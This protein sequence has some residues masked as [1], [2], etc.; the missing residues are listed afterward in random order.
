MDDTEL[1]ATVKSRLSDGVYGSSPVLSRGRKRATAFY[2][3]L[4]PA[5]L[6]AGNSSFISRDVFDAVEGRK[7]SLLEAFSGNAKPVRFAPTNQQDTAMAEIASVYTD[8]V[9]MRQNNGYQIFHDTIHDSL[10][11]ARN[12]IVQIDWRESHKVTPYQLRNQN[13]DVAMQLLLAFQDTLETYS[14]ETNEDGTVNVELEVRE[15]TSKVHIDV[16]PP[17]EFGVANHTVSLHTT[18]MCWRRKTRTLAWLKRAGY[19]TAAIDNLATDDSLPV[20]DTEAIERFMDVDGGWIEPLSDQYHKSVWVY[21]CY[22]TISD[23]TSGKETLWHVVLAQDTIL[24]KEEVRAHPFEEYAALRIP[25]RFFGEDFAG[26]VIP[27]QIAQTLL[28]RSVIDSALVTTNPR[29]TVLRGGLVNP[30]E[31]IENRLGGIVNV[32]R[33]DAVTP[34]VQPSLNPM[35]MSVIDRIESAKQSITGTSDLQQGLSKDVL[36]N[37]NSSDLV[38]QM[39]SLGQTRAKIMAR[40]FADFVRRVYLKTYNLVIENAK[41]QDVVEVA[42]N[43]VPVNP[44]DWNER[45]LVTVEFALGYNEREKEAAQLFQYDQYMS[46]QPNMAPSYTNTERFN[47]WTDIMRLNGRYDISR[48]LKDPSTLPP[49]QPSQAEQMQAELAQR[50]MAVKEQNAQSAAIKAQATQMGAVSKGQASSL[51]NALKVQGAQLKVQQFQEQANTNH[52]EIN[53]QHKALDQGHL[54]AMA[55]LTQTTQPSR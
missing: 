27:V 26:L 43:W 11:G 53:L 54:Q 50:E 36:S 15:D 44:Q 29:Y 12:G 45:K 5:P 32:T 19:D 9:V 10:V 41:A 3:G 46:A 39:A 1:L 40:N 2:K 17:E 8:Y 30:R 4:E 37:Q 24:H 49:Q 7:A 28:T 51:S 31:L 22:L 35:T 34:M 47:V 25:H 14:I 55:K 38:Q 52:A 16:V 20:D 42:G 48:Y 23:D 6:H 33:P 13:E 18:P 21:D